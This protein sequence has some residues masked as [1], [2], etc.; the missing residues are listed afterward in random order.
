M[1]KPYA[2]HISSLLYVIVVLLFFGVCY[3]YHVT[4]QEQFQLFLFTP[5]Y[6]W[7]ALAVPGGLADYIGRFFTQVFLYSWAGAAIMAVLLGAVQ[8]ATWLNIKSIGSFALS[9][10][11]SVILWIFFCHEASMLAVLVAFIM[12][13]LAGWSIGYIQN[14]WARRSVS[15]IM[16]PVLYMLLGPLV[17]VFVLIALIREYKESHGL[18]T[19][20]LMVLVMV[21]CPLCAQYVFNYSLARL[22][23]GL[24]Y[25]RFPEIAPTLVYVAVLA[26][27]IAMCFKVTKARTNIT[28]GILVA[29]IASG[30]IYSSADFNKEELMGYDFMV[31]TR[32]WNRIILTA[33][34]KAPSAPLSVSALNLALAQKGFLADHMFD[35]YQNGGQGM[36]PNFVRDFWLPLT[37]GEAFYYLGMTYVAQQYTYEAM[38]AIPDFQKSVRC[39]KRLAETNLINGD[40]KVA[41][42]YLNQLQHT[43]LYGSWAEETLKLLGNEEAI[44]N[45]PEYGKLR[46]SAYKEDFYVSDREMASMLGQLYM[47]NRENQMAFDYLMGWTMLNGDMENFPSYF[48]IS[49]NQSS[50]DIPSCYQQALV[51]S[52]ALSHPSP[53]GMPWSISSNILNGFNAFVQAQRQNQSAEQ[54][55]A[56]YGHTY[57][58]Y[59]FYSK[60]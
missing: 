19:D 39:Y 43:L 52:W 48:S 51:L 31:R 58:Y 45:H 44:N 37:P 25:S 34:K 3:P 53:E 13:L 56:Q 30:G 2:N 28:L 60:S 46:K 54:M 15:L 20:G 32:Q 24:H 14:L 59:Y 49:N 17:A 57:W 36:F 10:L 38:E 11:P 22:F 55:K 23:Y 1:M 26:V 29:L 4:Y 18:I 41:R 5:D 42:K 12:S 47:S 9:F 35:Y 27:V 16:I 21:L 33:N 40:Y 8:L 50:K 6:F 7:E